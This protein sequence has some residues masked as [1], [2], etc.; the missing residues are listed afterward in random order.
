MT[1]QSKTIFF[2]IHKEILICFFL[3]IANLAVYWQVRNHDF[4]AFDDDEYV[5]ENTHIKEG[6]TYKGIKWAFTDSYSANWHPV[7]WLSHILDVE[8]Y[9][10]NPGQ[11]HLTN[12]LFHIAN[13]ILLFLVFRD[14]TGALWQSSFIA[15]LFGL[16]PLHVESVAWISERKDVLSTFFWLLTM[17]FYVSYTKSLKIHK[18]LTAIFFFI[19]GL[20]AKPMLVTL[21]FVLLLLDYYPLKRLTIENWEL[22]KIISLLSEKI[23]FFIIAA[24]SSLITVF[25]QKGEGAV[26]SLNIYPMNIRIANALTSYISYILKMI[27][28]YDLSVYY[29]YRILPLWKIVFAGVLLFAIF[30][31]VILTIKQY[32]WFAV[33]WLW[34]FGTLV[35]VIGLVQV[36]SQAM[37]DR[38]T[39]VPLIGLFMI[40]AWGVPELLSRWMIKKN[41]IIIITAPVISILMATSWIQTQYWR[42]S[43]T[44]FQHAVDVTTNNYIAHYN[45]GS[46]L[47][48]KGRSD[49][50][51]REYSKVLQVNP[52]YINAHNNIGLILASQGRRDE[53]I[54]HFKEIFK[55][56]P[57]YGEAHT[58]LGA[59][60]ADAGRTDEAI[61]HFSEAL[62]LNP[63][64]AIAHNNLGVILFHMGKTDE[65]ILHFQKSLRINPDYYEAY[66][67]LREILKMKESE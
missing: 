5:F 17:K 7:T 64:D 51:M 4:V 60:L 61:A 28:P 22:K 56:N 16:H 38:Y 30:F 35:P 32:Q 57:A 2:N 15:A 41:I 36:G 37:A 55:I 23:P 52:K 13:T 45:L 6:L 31:L 40:I 44:L 14:M 34:Y 58:N 18:Y 47:E 25:A 10:M 62:R 1:S 53:A 39:Y 67:N 66:S 12:L 21:P 20:M 9:G 33:G 19:T 49:E 43:I 29:P 24:G 8:L 48:K 65:A 3:I 54:Q 26:A 11:H 50:A 59:I 27:L 46:A 42:N 63:D